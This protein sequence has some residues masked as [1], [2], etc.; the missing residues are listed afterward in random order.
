MSFHFLKLVLKDWLVYGDAETVEFNGFERGQNLIVVHGQNGFGK[1]SLLR[2]MQFLFHNGL[3]RDEWFGAW[4]DRAKERGE[5]TLEVSLDFIHNDRLCKLTRMVEFKPWGATL[6]IRPEVELWIDGEQVHGQVEDKI[7]QIIPK[8]TQQFVFFDGAEITRYA[9]KQYTDG[10][11]EA[12]ELVLGIPAVRN[13]RDDLSKLTRDL[14][15]EQTELLA[16]Q[17]QNDVLLAE[18]FQREGELEGYDSRR[19]K[20]IE[21]RDSI[22]LTLDELEQE[23]SEIQLI[24]T[25]RQRLAEKRQRRAELDERLAELNKA[26]SDL[27]EKAPRY[28][29]AGKLAQIV[30]ER[31]VQQTP[32]SRKVELS[33]RVKFLEDILDR[34]DC[35]CGRIIDRD[36]EGVLLAEIERLKALMFDVPTPESGSTSI[37]ELTE[38]SG[39]LK[40]IRSESQ[41]GHELMDR[42]ATI[43]T[44]L[45]EIETDIRKL[46]E[47]LEHHSEVEVQELFQQRKILSQQLIDAKA[48][49]QTVDAS[50]ARTREQ[51]QDLNRERDQLAA[52]TER[53]TQVTQTLDVV[54]RM[55][56]AID[57]YVELMVLEKRRDIEMAT[58]EI[59]TS[60][61]NKPLEYAGVHV[62]DDYT[63]AVYRRDE[64]VVE[65]TKLSAGEK[66]VLAYSFIT[67][68][69]LS[70]QNPAPFVMDTPFGHLDSGHRE[71]LLKSLPMLPVQVFLLATDRDLP[72]EERDKVQHA[73]AQ[74]F[75]IEREQTNALSHIVEV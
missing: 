11:K 74:E 27:L 70:S 66:E 20:L 43:E 13:L 61:T 72:E 3:S 18:I 8:E 16:A 9:H 65:N 35:I 52:S 32:P 47:K 57:E 6:S 42:R 33:H 60:I 48:D 1:T 21:K 71:G 23:A 24:E 64:T 55:H 10:V 68:L 50:I 45:E 5:G 22:Q 58:S 39:I 38:L 2:A 51:L 54:R 49:I 69:N 62:K 26:I 73:I 15:T 37:R 44:N 25:E 29:L 28:M 75:V 7:A 41:D 46:M 63:L 59:F 67:A 40:D 30:E 4:N 17:G 36:V 31:T 56:A 19:N 34:D 14:E 53:G 12:I